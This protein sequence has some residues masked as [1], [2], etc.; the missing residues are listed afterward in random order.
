VWQCGNEKARVADNE[1]G[2]EILNLLLKRLCFS[3]VIRVRF[4]LVICCRQSGYISADFDVYSHG[5]TSDQHMLR[6]IQMKMFATA[7]KVN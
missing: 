1:T 2:I 4:F 5:C 7:V 3:P 6:K